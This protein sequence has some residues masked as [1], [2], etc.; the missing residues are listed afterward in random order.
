M[1]ILLLT[2]YGQLGASSRMRFLLYVPSL[3][4]AGIECSVAPLFDDNQL[5]ERYRKKRYGFSSLVQSYVRR[6]LMLF[7]K[8]YFDLV[9]I[10]KEALPW[11]P[12]WFERWFL[13]DVP[14]VLDYDDAIFHNYDLHSSPVVRHFF[15]NRID[16]LMADARLVVA[17]NSYLAQRAREVGAK[18]EIVPTL[19]D[20][21]RYSA[22][23]ISSDEVDL[24]KIVWVGSPSTIRYLKLLYKPLVELSR[25]FVFKLR[26][27]GAD[28][29]AIE[30]VNVECVPWSE[31]TEA[32]SIRECDVGVMPL[33]DSPWE[34]GKC[35]Y[36]LIQ[37][38]ACG[39]P[40]VASPVG[41]NSEIVNN[42]QNGYLA[43]TD[44]AWVDALGALLG[45]AVLRQQMGAAGRKR[46]EDDYCIQ[47]V[48]PRM[49]G[50]LRAAGEGC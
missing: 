17:G 32:A 27:I 9:W 44:G 20:L 12:A 39:L 42:G 47:Q 34:R 18:V 13:S 28:T 48:A 50:L 45:D 6:L 14:Y 21:D 35:G 4:G 22:K 29:F 37:Y 40:V 23:N 5:A 31:A 25:Q 36:K 10:E 41:V 46:V 2:R 33:L 49:I 19:I 16:H 8:R 38:M 11:L 24:L 1:K 43:D 15:S 7:K 3:E 30:G 26:V